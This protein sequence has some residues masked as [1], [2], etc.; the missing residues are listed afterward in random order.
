MASTSIEPNKITAEL[1]KMFL[2]PQTSE[3]LTQIIYIRHF[4]K[5]GKWPEVDNKA[6]T[7]V[8]SQEVL[9]AI[10]PA[11]GK[12]HP[13]GIDKHGLILHFAETMLIEQSYTRFNEKTITNFLAL[14]TKV[15][16]YELK[17]YF[18]YSSLTEITTIFNVIDT[19]FYFYFIGCN[20][21][22]MEFIYNIAMMCLYR[23]YNGSS[24]VELLSFVRD[25]REGIYFAI[26]SIPTK[27]VELTC[28]YPYAT[29]SIIV[30]NS[31]L[32]SIHRLSNESVIVK[33]GVKLSS[34]Q[35]MKDFLEKE[36]STFLK[37]IKY[38]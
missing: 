6:L 4:I 32:I 28:K 24:H 13:H 10:D 29:F 19:L 15:D 25:I 20:N 33:Y 16:N 9:S 30:E 27:V 2:T 12:R 36:S 1:R 5:H 31:Q 17:I 21:I 22:W 34:Y 38:I 35:T 8:V 26:R 37:Y 14:I 23:S 18:N 7:D 3:P 11:F